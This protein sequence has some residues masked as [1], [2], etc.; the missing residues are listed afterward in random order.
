MKGDLQ[1]RSN[2]RLVLSP[3]QLCYWPMRNLLRKLA[4]C[5]RPVTPERFG[6]AKTTVS[7]IKHMGLTQ[8]GPLYALR[9]WVFPRRAISASQA[10]IGFV[11]AHNLSVFFVPAQTAA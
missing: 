11:I 6:K 9:R 3:A 4:E 2:G 8:H 1:T 10:S 5:F 7:N